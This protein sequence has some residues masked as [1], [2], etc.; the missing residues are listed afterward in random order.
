MCGVA[1]SGKSAHA[2]ELTAQGYVVLSF[3]A[4]AWE[5]GHR[6]HP[7]G[8]GARAEVHAALQERLRRSVTSGE[9]VVVDSS[10]WSRASRD[11]YR[12]LLERWNVV[13][14]VHHV[15]APRHVVLERLARRRNS[16]PDDIA[17]PTDLAHAYLEG[18]EAPRGDEGPVVQIDGSAS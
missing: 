17:V 1:G 5:L 12:R 2:R 8:D 14:V 11:E 7:L 6:Q 9:N 10:F 13:P 16:G 15:T 18:F 3:D 4:L